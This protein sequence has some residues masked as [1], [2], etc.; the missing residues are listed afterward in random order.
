MK[1]YEMSEVYTAS[2]VAT[3][4]GVAIHTVHRWSEEFSRYLSAMA[5]PQKGKQRNYTQDDLT[6]LLYVATSKK[7][8]FTFEQIHAALKMGERAAIPET[9]PTDLKALV[10]DDRKELLAQIQHYAREIEALRVE[11][12]QLRGARD[13]NIGLKAELAIYKARADKADQLM[14]EI[15]R[16]EHEIETLRGNP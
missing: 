13:E 1:G 9:M 11:L 5:N 4:A 14:R 10:T 6:V 8:G 16:L 3:L 7:S 2:T 15:G 12:D